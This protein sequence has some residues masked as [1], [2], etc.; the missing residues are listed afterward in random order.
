MGEVTFVNAARQ[1]EPPSFVR[2]PRPVDFQVVLFQLPPDPRFK[3]SRWRLL[4]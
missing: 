3:P 1:C 4:V 2:L